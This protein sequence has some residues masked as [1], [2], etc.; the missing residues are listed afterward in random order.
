MPLL[1]A[2][3]L[4]PLPHRTCTE[5]SV[6]IGHLCKKVAGMK[7]EG[8][9]IDWLLAL[10]LYHFLKEQSEPFGEPELTIIWEREQNLGLKN[11]QLK[12][13]KTEK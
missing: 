8:S 7:S 5:V 11:A 4:S 6:Y 9:A 12:A 1:L 3:S 2:T 10:P 13:S